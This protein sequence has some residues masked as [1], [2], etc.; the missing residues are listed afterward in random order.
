LIGV[1]G[2]TDRLRKDRGRA[3]FRIWKDVAKWGILGAILLGVLMTDAWQKMEMDS[4]SDALRKSQLKAELVSEQIE[5]ARSQLQDASF[6][7][8]EA[9]ILSD[10]TWC[11][12]T[13]QNTVE[14]IV[15]DE[16]PPRTTLLAEQL[17]H[18]KKRMTGFL[19]PVAHAGT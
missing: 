3:V 17:A 1:Y 18:W 11:V 15:L 6:E 4:L 14:L 19:F 2:H 12:P 10:E 5:A 8:S 16:E 9:A 13:L 7:L